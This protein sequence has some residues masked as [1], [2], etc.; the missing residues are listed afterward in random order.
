MK[1]LV[2]F[3]QIED[4]YIR[5]TEEEFQQLISDVYEAGKGDSNGG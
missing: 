3:Q 1:P 2:I 5:F 4:G